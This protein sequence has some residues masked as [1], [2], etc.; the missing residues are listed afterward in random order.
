MLLFYF[1][2]P[3]LEFYSQM[4][5]DLDKMIITAEIS[6]DTN[7]IELVDTTQRRYVW[8]IWNLLKFI[9]DMRVEKGDVKEI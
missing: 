7:R 8:W 5:G 9:I 4:E 2:H 3:R 6:N 1:L